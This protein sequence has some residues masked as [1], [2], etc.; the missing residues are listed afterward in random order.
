MIHR[1]VHMDEGNYVDNSINRAMKTNITGIERANYLLFLRTNYSKEEEMI[2]ITSHGKGSGR[3]TSLSKILSLKLI[4]M[5]HPLPRAS[6][7][8][9]W[10][11]KPFKS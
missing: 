8:L 5:E 10:S 9:P 1:A 2:K 7:F 11:Q 6:R 4:F 3:N